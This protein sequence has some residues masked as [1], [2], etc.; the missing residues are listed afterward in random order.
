MR[1]VMIL[2]S[3]LTMINVSRADTLLDNSRLRY[4]DYKMARRYKFKDNE[5]EKQHAKASSEINSNMYQKSIIN[6]FEQDRLLAA[7]YTDQAL[8]NL[9]KVADTMLRAESHDRL[10][11]EIRNQFQTFYQ[12]AVKRK[13]LGQKEMGDHPPMS[14]WLDEV[15]TKIHDALGDMI[16]QYTHLHDIEILNHGIPVV[17]SP[18]K[19]E[20][21]DYLDHFS[22]HLIWGWWWE[23]HGVAGVVTYWLIDGAC[24]GASYGLGIIIFVCSPIATYAEHVMD[25]HLAPPIG[26]R[27]WNRSQEQR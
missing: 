20:L 23:H 26:E 14:Q 9:F 17:F 13:L 22:G 3:L 21:K 24:I 19:Y 11:D 2:V 16:C 10:A 18:E 12:G 4:D 15:H 27:I 1:I 25:K 8:T 6:A 5:L 7:D